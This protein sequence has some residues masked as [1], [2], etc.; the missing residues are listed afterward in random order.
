MKDFV[1]FSSSLI[2]IKWNGND[3]NGKDR[4]EIKVGGMKMDE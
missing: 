4:V 3:K 2:H 1:F